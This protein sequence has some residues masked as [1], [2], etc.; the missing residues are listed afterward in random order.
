MKLK[1]KIA[2]VTGG[3]RG[4][5]QAI[6]ETFAREGATVV[7]TGRKRETLDAVAAATPG[8]VPIASHAGKAADT[9]ALAADVLKR[10][11]R[12]DVLVNNAAT[13]IAHGSCLTFTDDQFDKMVDLNLKS[14]FRLVRLFAPGMVE[15]H[16]GS[17][18]NIASVAGIKAQP[19]SLLYSVTKAALIMMTKSMALE[20][21]PNNV[22]VNAICPGL[23]QTKLSEFF[24]KDDAS[25]KVFMDHQ[26]LKHLGQP[27]EIASV[28]LLLA[29]GDGSYITGQSLVVD[30]G[31][32]TT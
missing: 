5:G 7:I 28:A 10:F 17:I 20:F 9:D 6:A 29:S 32:L 30:G 18:I 23:I 11:G 8:I 14:A 16:D 26:L 3:S 22:R 15:R 4:I 1:G 13:N 27:S 21:S 19:D 25:R 2:V 31:F 12:V 24:W